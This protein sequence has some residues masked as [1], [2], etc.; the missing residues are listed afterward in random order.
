MERDSSVG[1]MNPRHRHKKVEIV[2]PTVMK[3]LPT[4][5]ITV[6]SSGSE[7]GNVGGKKVSGNTAPLIVSDDEQVLPTHKHKVK[8]Q[9]STHTM[10]RVASSPDP[11]TT[12]CSGLKA[13]KSLTQT[14]K[15]TQFQIKLP[16]DLELSGEESLDGRTAAPMPVQNIRADSPKNAPSSKVPIKPRQPSKELHPEQSMEV[17]SPPQ[18]KEDRPVSMPSCD[19]GQLPS[20]PSQE[21]SGDEYNLSLTKSWDPNVL[22]HHN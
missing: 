15:R 11:N 19:G 12:Y 14:T 18:L 22:D 6:N 9:Q 10:K 20:M 16:L 4:S 5:V 2:I 8:S 3:R 7:E 1:P 13:V 21:L 17:Q